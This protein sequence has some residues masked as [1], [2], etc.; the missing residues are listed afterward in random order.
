MT[1]SNGDTF[2][3]KGITNN[4][5]SLTI[6]NSTAS[7]SNTGTFANTSL[8]TNNGTF[9]N[10]TNGSGGGYLSNNSTYATIENNG[11]ILLQA[12]STVTNTNGATI[13]NNE[14]EVQ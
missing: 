5:G 6:N 7:I 11:I 10:A 2:V 4:F 9:T 14:V 13:L 8:F 3:N 12:N 1:I